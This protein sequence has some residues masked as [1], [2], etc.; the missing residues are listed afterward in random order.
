MFPTHCGALLYLCYCGTLGLFWISRW[1]CCKKKKKMNLAA[2]CAAQNWWLSVLE[3]FVECSWHKH[4]SVWNHCA[5]VQKLPH[6]CV[7]VCVII[8]LH[9]LRVGCS[10]H[11]NHA[12]ARPCLHVRPCRSSVGALRPVK[13]G[14]DPDICNPALNKW[15]DNGCVMNLTMRQTR[16][17]SRWK[18]RGANVQRGWP[19][20]SPLWCPMV[21]QDKTLGCAHLCFVSCVSPAFKKSDLPVS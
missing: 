21:L 12:K 1:R 5:N 20:L 4:H 16:I 10:L 11:I 19:S 9:L 18:Q 3:R 17:A 13:A 2:N 14:M 7:C 8:C 15:P 6:A